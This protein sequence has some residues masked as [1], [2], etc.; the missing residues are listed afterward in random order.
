MCR[1]LPINPVPDSISS[2]TAT[3][4]SRLDYQFS[5]L[6][7]LLFKKNCKLHNYLFIAGWSKAN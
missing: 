4:F 5:C 2:I 6:I 3:L 1:L 7:L